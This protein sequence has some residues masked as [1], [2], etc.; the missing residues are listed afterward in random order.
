M[1]IYIYIYIYTKNLSIEN[2]D[3]KQS[4]LFRL[5]SISKNERKPPEK[6]SV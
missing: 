4:D 3:H 5:L 1:Y 6:I 2:A